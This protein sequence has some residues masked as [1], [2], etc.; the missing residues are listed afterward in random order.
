[1][2]LVVASSALVLAVGGFARIQFASATSPA[3]KGELADVVPAL[4]PQRA[5]LLANGGFEQPQD[6]SD[7]PQAWFATRLPRTT[8]HFR[9]T[10]S[11]SVVH[12]GQ[13]SVVVEI[14]DRHPASPVHYNWTAD[15][16]GWQ[17]GQTYELSGWVKVENANRP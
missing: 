6:F 12:S 13:R 10:V 7:D 14:G 2:K 3:R 11:R 4:G 16:K 17:A 15:A 9:L 8:G 5:S 1:K